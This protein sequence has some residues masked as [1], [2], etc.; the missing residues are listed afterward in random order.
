MKMIKKALALLMALAVICTIPLSASAASFDG[1]VIDF[2]KSASV[3][4]YKYDLTGAEKD[5]VWDS[6]Y[7]S[8]GVR[9]ES[10][11]EAILG[12]PSR[13]SSL[14]ANGTAYGYAVPGVEF[15][16]LKVAD[17]RA[18][19][20]SENGAEHVEVLYGIK[21]TETTNA[22]LSAIGL[23]TDDRYAP[24]DMQES[25]QTVYYYQ[26]DKLIAGLQAALS[27]NSTVVKNK[28]ERYVKDNG[29]TAMAE[30]D[31]YGHSSASNLPLGLYLF[32]ETRVPEMVVDTTDPFLLSLPMTTV[33]GSNATNGGEA[34]NYDVTV[35]PKNITGIPSLEKTVREAKAD[36]GKHG[37]STSDITD[38]Y[39]HTASASTGDLVDYQIISTLP[40]IT[41][42][43][44]YLSE[45]TFVDT[46]AP[47]LGYKKNDV[48]LEFFKDSACTD[49]I[50]AWTD[51]S[52]K[53]SVSY[54]TGADGKNVMTITL[55]PAG[56]TELNTSTAV[57][58]GASMVNSGFSDCTLRV[59]YQARIN[60]DSTV[61][62]G[63]AGNSNAVVLQWKRTNSSYYDTLVDDCHV[64]VYG[65]DVTKRFSDG[66]G[67][68]SKVEFVAYNNTDKYFLLATPNTAECVWYVTGHTTDE[69]SATHFVPNAQG[70]LMIKGTED[71]NYIFAEV[72]TAPGYS[73]L[74]NKIQ[75][76]IV[77][78][79]SAAVCD[80]YSTDALGL[81]QNDPRFANVSA[82]SYHNMPQKHL[83]HKA[84]TAAAAVD[85]NRVSMGKDGNS[86]N[87]FVPF[88]VVNTKGFD[89]PQTGSRGNWMFP[90]IGI[91]GLS[92]AVLGIFLLS[93]KKTA[94][95]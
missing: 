45:Y 65:I 31:A 68:M 91:S 79:E 40:S 72:K 55:T 92:I 28:L 39:T 73:L 78:S 7:V 75:V 90:V 12:N 71:D 11:V 52:G 54:N 93:R 83:E 89:L 63:D 44:S 19:S 88:N 5:G 64:Y 62:F 10:G 20:V 24:A 57:Y 34:W 86:D 8:T 26:S 67:D 49:Y 23:S 59:S 41:S 21:P 85:G 22:F 37:G 56:L 81:I 77:Q 74:K 47:G 48:L 18:F 51:N 50:T 1:A 80:I 58:S 25:G 46:L 15:T 35:Y 61:V 13:V 16:Y 38:G 3:N 69:A 82:G 84:L 94:Q 30:T 33:N 32:V 4:L 70:K 36:T 14:N 6:S 17:I 9:D 42:A 76:A 27:T 53:F 87:A 95:D 29:G 43:A 66:Q 60:A 2:T